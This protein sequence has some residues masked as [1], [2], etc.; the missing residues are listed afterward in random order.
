VVSK[1]KTSGPHSGL[2]ASVRS[3]ARNFRELVSGELRAKR[4]RDESIAHLAT[5]GD[6]P[7]IGCNPCM[8]SDPLEPDARL[9]PPATPRP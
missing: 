1:R 4:L 9:N 6:R 8:A 2:E 5:R 7:F 3:W